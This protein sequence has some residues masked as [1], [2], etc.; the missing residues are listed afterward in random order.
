MLRLLDPRQDENDLLSCSLDELARLGARKLLAEALELEVAEYIARHK[1]EVDEAGHRQ[2]VRNGKARERRITTGAGT[3]SV[4][5]PRVDDRRPEKS[6]SSSILPPYLRRS[7]NV[8]SILPLLYL[9]GLSGNAFQEALCGLLGED[10]GGLS[11][12]SIAT[13]KKRWQ[14]D[15]QEWRQQPISDNFVYLWA[16]G[17][18]RHEAPYYPV[19]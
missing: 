3:V 10:A 8:E 7:A 14:Q 9:K 1:H 15:A 6:F 11:S 4:R 2:V 13:L 12:S 5:A 18:V 16:D 19:G 17:V